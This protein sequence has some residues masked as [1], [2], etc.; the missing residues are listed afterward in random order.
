MAF[1]ADQVQGVFGEF[2]TVLD[3]TVAF[4]ADQV[5]GV[6]GQFVPVLDAAAVGITAAIS[7]TAVADMTEAEVVAGGQTII[8]D[9]SGAAWIDT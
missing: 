3:P 6:F 5:Q 2:V 7:G 8:I 9:L 4:T 1:T